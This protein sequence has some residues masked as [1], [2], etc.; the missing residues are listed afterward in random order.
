MTG[1]GSGPYGL[2]PYGGDT[3]PGRLPTVHVLL[4][5]G[6]GTFPY[7]L[8]DMGGVSY[9]LLREG[10]SL[11]R[12]RQDW[13][14]GV[15]AGSLSL[16]LNNADGRFTP[17]STIIASPSPIKVDQRIRVTE[18]VNGTTF[19]R[20]TG[21][22]KQW[23]VAWPATVSTWATVQVVATDAQARAER[24]VLRSVIEE[25]VLADGPRAY[26]TLAEPD[27]ATTAADHSG[28]GSPALAM[29]GTGA[30][31]SFGVSD[32]GAPNPADTVAAFSG[33][34]YLRADLGPVIPGAAEIWFKTSTN[35]AQTRPLLGVGYGLFLQSGHLIATSS[36]TADAGAVADGVWHHAV[37]Q[38]TDV[39][40]DGVLATSN[41]FGFD[42]S[43]E[44]DL[45]VGGNSVPQYP[46]FIGSIAHVAIY[47][48]A[49][50]GTQISNHHA[51]GSTRFA[52]E[53]GTARIGRIARYGALTL[54]TLDT[55]LTNVAAAD[56]AG[57]SL[58]DQIQAVA[59]AEFGVVFTDGS[60]KLTFQNRNR[61]A[62]KTTPDLTMDK[63][64]V[65]P[66]VQ[67][68]H[69]DQ[70]ILNYIEATAVGTGVAQLA[71]NTS[72]ENLHGRYSDS[73][74]YL[75]QTDAEALDRANW[76]LSNFAEPTTRYGTLT[77]NLYA[78]PVATQALVLG[79]LEIGAWL[80]ITDMPTQN[81]GGATV[82]LVVEGYSEQATASSW[83]LTLNVV[84][85]YLFDALILGDST[86]GVLD[87]GYRLYV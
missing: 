68:M 87:A 67:P 57:S 54:A 29:A 1:Y 75:V 25:E 40:L 47:S 71:R 5:D 44:S 20:F 37:I 15:T 35:D 61:V 34:T 49:L 65:T 39:Y 31:V 22:V 79:A 72:S 16:T 8:T 2:G 23:P 58:W 32:A 13:Q 82:D 41:F 18:T 38:G 17:G 70:Q 83:T 55:S 66:D 4:D 30:A 27:T 9:V 24:R 36:T 73:K 46:E 52:G 50:T 21:Y 59:D 10:L 6:T 53:S 14:G 76:I 74:N 63:S 84:S 42:A 19:T 3:T 33:S 12:G 78:M 85:K 28:T 60:G 64:Y 86:R 48:G 62:V 69:D 26:Y 11:S 7:D 56:F 45:W 51:A 81:T 77:V 80:Q 43:H